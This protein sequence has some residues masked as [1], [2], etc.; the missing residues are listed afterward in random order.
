MGNFEVGEEDVIVDDSIGV[1]IAEAN[2]DIRFE[3]IRIDVHLTELLMQASWFCRCISINYIQKVFVWTDMQ[4]H[5]T[6]RFFA[7]T[8]SKG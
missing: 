5:K 6:S 8:E 1:Q 2:R 3:I 4:K 7:S